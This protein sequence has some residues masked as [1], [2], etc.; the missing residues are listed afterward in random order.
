MKEK[1]IG[2]ITI[3]NP[4]ENYGASLQCYALWKYL[5]SLGF[6]CEVINLLRP[7]SKEYIRSSKDT[8]VTK[9][10]FF[11]NVKEKLLTFFGIKRTKQYI[12][13]EHEKRFKNFNHKIQYSK[14]YYSVDELYSNP[15]MYDVYISGSD[16]IWNPNMPFV[17]EPYFLTF[18]PEKSIK[19]SY[20]SSFAIEIL[21]ENIKKNYAKWLSNYNYIT[22]REQSGCRIVEELINK[23]VSVALDPS[24]LITPEEWGQ[25]AK[26]V[27]LSKPYVF[28]YCLHYNSTLIKIAKN[29]A[30]E[31]NWDIVLIISERKR[32]MEDNVNQITNAGPEE[33][34]GWLKGAEYVITTSFHGTVFSMLFGVNF[35]T[36]IEKKSTTSDRIKTL[37]SIFNLIHHLVEL[38]FNEVEVGIIENIKSLEFNYNVFKKK[39]N[40]K[41]TESL[42]YLINSIQN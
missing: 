11:L 14:T 9:R 8:P 7:W 23:K 34:L 19:I 24:F 40:Q 3:Q 16:Q 22:V 20:A 10:I 35:L 15:P 1:K 38:D 6:E 21:P 29:I 25:L 27:R 31:H 26:D 37:L 41:R 2:I 36:V 28:V 13:L 32:V 5:S 18:A 4:P 42:N 33:W 12:D 30:N 17:N 39:L